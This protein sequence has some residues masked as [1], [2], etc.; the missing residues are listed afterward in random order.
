MWKNF[1]LIKNNFQNYSFTLFN[2]CYLWQ[3]RKDKIPKHRVVGISRLKSALFFLQTH[4]ISGTIG[5]WPA[6]IRIRIKIWNFCARTTTVSLNTFKNYYYIGDIFLT[7]FD[8]GSTAP[9]GLRPP[10]SWGFYITHTLG[11]TPPNERTVRRR[12]RYLHNIQQTQQTN[13]YVFSGTQTLN[14]SFEIQY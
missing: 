2:F 10:Y 11:R 8:R 14:T 13:I 5:D 9:L 1:T 7:N 12:G 6:R 3:Q 4:E